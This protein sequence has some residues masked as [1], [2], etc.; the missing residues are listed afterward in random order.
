MSRHYDLVIIGGGAAGFFAAI[1]AAEI[2]PNIKIAI[3]EKSNK[4]L[5]KVKV[6][7]GGRCNVTNACSIPNELAAFYPRGG[8]EL[9]AAF[10][11]FNSTDTIEWFSKKNVEL[12]AQ[13]DGRIFPV[14]NSSQTIIDCF[15]LCIKKYNIELL[16]DTQVSDV[17]KSEN[18]FILTACNGNVFSSEFLLLASG[19]SAKNEAYS[20]PEKLQHTIISP[21]PSLFT[22]NLPENNITSLMGLS[23]PNV[24]LKISG[25]NFSSSGPLLITH[26][27][28]S[29]PAVLKLSAIA[30]RLLHENNYIFSFTVNWIGGK[31]ANIL[32][33]DLLK[34]KIDAPNKNI[35]SANM[36]EIPNRLW[37]YFLEKAN[38]SF[39][40]TYAE[41]SNK[42]ILKLCE[43]LTNDVFSAYG[44]TTFKEEFVTAGGV[45]LKEINFKSMESKMVSNL[46]FAG[47]V[48]DVDG[49]TGGFNFQAAWTTAFIASKTIAERVKG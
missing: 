19:G 46:F 37:I 3:L 39:N 43:I 12:Y 17:E 22:F 41:I 8:K 38:I 23:M 15:L 5:S 27:G 28:V 49:L 45:S 34:M 20:I 10:H 47:E 33:E 32:R 44:K 1:N 25:T 9:V 18:D 4:V 24:I 40:K 14:S 7:G 29:G 6:S 30:A 36:L 31:N 26:W 48:I 21:V 2:Q 35:T 42:E 16:L 13:N 11:Q